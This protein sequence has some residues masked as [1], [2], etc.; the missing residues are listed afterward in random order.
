MFDENFTKF[1]LEIEE[2]DEVYAYKTRKLQ[3]VLSNLLHN[4]EP[5]VLAYNWDYDNASADGRHL[6]KFEKECLHIL[7]KSMDHHF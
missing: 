4:I 5:K 2:A 1:H 3:K 6:T 7:I